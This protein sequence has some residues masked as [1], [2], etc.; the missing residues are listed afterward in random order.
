MSATMSDMPTRI[1]YR[2]GHPIEV[3]AEALEAAG[4]ADG[5]T[6]EI[7]TTSLGAVIVHPVTRVRHALEGEDG[8]HELDELL[9]DLDHA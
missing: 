4:L 7:E 6:L 1:T 9:E 5:A 8:S 2:K 3:P